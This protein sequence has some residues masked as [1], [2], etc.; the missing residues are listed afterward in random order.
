MV[1]SHLGK[2]PNRQ[3]PASSDTMF[4]CYCEVYSFSNFG[5]VE[6]SIMLNE[7]TLADARAVLVETETVESHER[8]VDLLSNCVLVGIV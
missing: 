1:V 3:T 4:M 7:K 5:S 2:K 6:E 8:I